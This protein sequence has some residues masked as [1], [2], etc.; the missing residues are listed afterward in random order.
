VYETEAM[1]DATG[2]RDFYNAAVAI[3]TTL[4]P[5]ELLAA[6]KTIE[7]QLGRDPAGRRHAPRPIDLDLLLLGDLQL[8]EPGL[9][10]PHPGV[11]ARRF[12]LEPLLELDAE[13]ALPGGRRLADALAALGD[14]QRV[15]RLGRLDSG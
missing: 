12:V 15:T 9:A 10:L 6:C 5:R 1:D 14:A 2:Q 3:D 7:A 8:D 11:S 4:A 13:L